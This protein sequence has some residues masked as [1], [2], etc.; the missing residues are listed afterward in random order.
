LTCLDDRRQPGCPEAAAP[1]KQVNRFKHTGFSGAVG[2]TDHIQ[3]WVGFYLHIIQ[4]A[5]MLNAQ[6]KNRHG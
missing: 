2:T 4:T 3:A 6:L 1:A 5:K